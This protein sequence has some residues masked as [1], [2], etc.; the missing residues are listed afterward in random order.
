MI[1]NEKVIKYKVLYFF[2][3]STTFIFVISSSD[4]V[5]KIQILNVRTSNIIFHRYMITNKKVVYY[6]VLSLF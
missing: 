3:R 5:R 2:L 4:I 6:K 1:L